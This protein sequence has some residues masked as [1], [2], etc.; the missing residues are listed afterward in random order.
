MFGNIINTAA[1]I[2]GGFIGTVFNRAL[3]QRYQTII[4]QGMG[5]FV[6]ALGISMAIKMEHVLISVFSLLLGGLVG[7]FFRLDIQINKF[8][9]WLK[10][11]LK[12]KSDRFTEGF[13]SA[14]LIYCTG[15]MAVLGAIEEGT[16]QF[17]TILL[18]K[19][20]MDG[21]SSIAFASA[22]GIGVV[23]AAGS[24]AIYQGA[25]ILFVMLFAD[26]INT[27]IVNELSAVGGVLLVGL[28]IDLL[29]IK[30][31]KVVNLLPALVFVVVM[32][33]IF[34]KT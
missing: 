4:F 5:L 29:E 21:F 24:T 3:P 19:S 10:R 6:L 23:F 34:V 30:K 31:I 25:I 22:L 12:F 27:A 32:M 26:T 17:P 28:G 20:V 14:S 8:G 11:K 2:V 18:T 13:V 1:I 15:A 16:G 7:E 33:L 9:D